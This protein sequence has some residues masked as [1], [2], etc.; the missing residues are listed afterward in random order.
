MGQYFKALIKDR[1]KR[2]VYNYRG[3]SKLMEHSYLTNELTDAV[4]KHIYNIGPCRVAWIG[5]YGND[6][7]DTF[8]LTHRLYMKEYEYVWGEKDHDT[9]I[10]PSDDPEIEFTCDRLKD[11]ALV[12]HTKAVY[13]DFEKYI[14]NQLRV[15]N[16]E[17]VI[18]PLSILTAC[19]NHRGGGD[20]HGKQDELAGTW[21]F[22][23]VELTEKKNLSGLPLIPSYYS[24][25]PVIFLE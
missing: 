1:N 21:A 6:V 17:A 19:G 2:T 10:R 9:V 25:F 23:L 13:I 11:M 22:D 18:C 8:N 5:D 15:S 3:F 4:F 16:N 24:E 12:N 20:Y 7:C 14:A